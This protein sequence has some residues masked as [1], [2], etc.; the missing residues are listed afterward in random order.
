MINVRKSFLLIHRPKV[1]NQKNNKM[2]LISG[3]T[4]VTQVCEIGL[5]SQMYWVVL[6]VAEQIVKVEKVCKKPVKIYFHGT[7]SRQV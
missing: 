3:S 2:Y 7:S 1:G 5:M 4:K 6:I